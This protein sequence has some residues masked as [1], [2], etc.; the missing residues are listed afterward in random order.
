[1]VAT[2][3][4]DETQECGSHQ[5]GQRP[6]SAT[7]RV[8]SSLTGMIL[9]TALA[10]QGILMEHALAEQFGVSKTPVRDALRLLA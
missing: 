4:R 2:S 6:V 5:T 9:A 10:P 7:H 1:M 3:Q 8:Y